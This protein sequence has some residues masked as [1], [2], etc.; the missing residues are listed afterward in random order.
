MGLRIVDSIWMGFVSFEFWPLYTRRNGTQYLQ[1]GRF[2]GSGN[3][4]PL[5]RHCDNRLKTNRICVI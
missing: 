5:A 2:A 4:V 1:D 3:R